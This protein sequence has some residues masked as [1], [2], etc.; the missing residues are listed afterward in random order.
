MWVCL[1]N[2][3]DITS[4]NVNAYTPSSPEDLL[5]SVDT[6]HD[7]EGHMQPVLLANWKIKD[8]GE[9]IP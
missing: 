2:C 6:R 3:L 4:V 9:F 5:V 1:G 7:D 8:D